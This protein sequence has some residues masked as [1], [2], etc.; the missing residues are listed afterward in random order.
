VTG[1]VRIDK[2]TMEEQQHPFE[3]IR[4]WSELPEDELIVT[5]HESSVKDVLN[6][7]IL[8]LLD[9]P[10]DFRE[11]HVED[12]PKIVKKLRRLIKTGSWDLGEAIIKSDD[13]AKSGDLSNAIKEMQEFI[14]SCESPFYRRCAEGHLNSIKKKF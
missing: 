14:S 11:Y 8:L 9:R 10:I 7:A 6:S 12:L 5:L 13:Y 1:G 2:T 3:L 4:I